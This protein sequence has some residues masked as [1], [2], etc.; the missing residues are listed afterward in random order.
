MHLQHRPENARW[1]AGSADL[2]DPLWGNNMF[3]PSLN[4]WKRNTVPRMSEI[5]PSCSVLTQAR[6]MYTKK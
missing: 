4:F 3:R 5:Y 2:E 6:F 1:E